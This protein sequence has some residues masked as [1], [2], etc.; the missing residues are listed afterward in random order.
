LRFFAAFFLGLRGLPMLGIVIRNFV[1][2]AA[3]KPDEQ[4]THEAEKD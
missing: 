3:Q 2:L 4:A 1:C